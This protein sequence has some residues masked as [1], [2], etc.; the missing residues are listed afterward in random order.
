[1]IGNNQNVR[2]CIAAETLVRKEIKMRSSWKVLIQDPVSRQSAEQ[3][4]EALRQVANEVILAL[5]NGLVNEPLTMEPPAGCPDVTAKRFSKHNDEVAKF[6][7]RRADWLEAFAS[8]PLRAAESPPGVKE[9]TELTEAR[10]SVLF[11]QVA[12][13]VEHSALLESREGLLVESLETLREHAKAA[14]EDLERETA[15]ADK[16]MRKAGYAPEE[17]RMYGVNPGA[18]QIRFTK[19][20]QEAA[21]VR[22][23][24]AVAQDANVQVGTVERKLHGIDNDLSIVEALRAAA[25]GEVVG[26]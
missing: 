15:K 4:S 8:L 19:K 12:I 5:S 17:D 16:A 3:R 2:S 24:A 10:K 13:F 11:D 7:K 1:M 21:P 25:I 9:L 18:A 22:A 26:M 6:V 23:A 14:A 20:V